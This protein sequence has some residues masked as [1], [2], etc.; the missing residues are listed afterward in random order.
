MY[1]C[2]WHV[3]KFGVKL[4]AQYFYL[5]LIVSYIKMKKIALAVC[6]SL[7]MFPAFAQKSCEELKSE[8]ATK[9]EARG[10]KK[11]QLE[12][13]AVGDVKDQKVVGVCEGGKKKIT[14]KKG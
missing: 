11:Y 5:F 8:I 6:L 9:L 12:I 10:V 14:Y 13:V 7:V 1:F 2:L 4:P 3:R